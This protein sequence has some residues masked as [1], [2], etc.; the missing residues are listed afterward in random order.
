MRELSDG[1]QYRE[2][3]DGM[4]RCT[5]CTDGTVR[6]WIDPQEP[7]KRYPGV[8]LLP[9]EVVAR[10]VEQTV[11]CP[12]C[13][14]AR[15][16]PKMVRTTREVPCPKDAALRMLLDEN[17]ETGRLVVFAGFTGLGGP[18]GQPVS[19]GEVERRAVRSRR[20]SGAHA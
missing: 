10:L 4:T 9:E 12:V 18:R 17:E 15:E 1:F 3:Q 6:E 8:Q 19:Q 5:H 16:V 11:P 7:E 2:M 20:V 14:G 13:G